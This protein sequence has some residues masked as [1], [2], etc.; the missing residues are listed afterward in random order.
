MNLRGIR[1]INTG[2]LLSVRE[3]EFSVRIGIAT[4][5]DAILDRLIHN[6]YTIELKGE[7]IAST[8]LGYLIKGGKKM[9]KKRS[10]GVT[11]FS[12]YFII[13]GMGSLVLIYLKP[14]WT[15]S[16]QYYYV[17]YNIILLV[18]AVYVFQLK[19]WARKWIIYLQILDVV[20]VSIFLIQ[21]G[22]L[23]ANLPITPALRIFVLV[24][25]FVA[26]M[27]APAVSIYF[28]TRPKVKEQFK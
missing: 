16:H 1:P 18:L 10:I 15:A 23:P 27:V 13:I 25:P 9:E 26:L 21:Q 19:E 5:A 4:L 20:I 3:Q 7:S 22:T 11:L 17:V 6:A 2:V 28:L 24:S 14:N 12:I 8:S